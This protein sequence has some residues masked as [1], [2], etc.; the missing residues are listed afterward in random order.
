MVLKL[1]PDRS[2]GELCVLD[3][4]DKND[5]NAIDVWSGS[6]CQKTYDGKLRERGREL[7]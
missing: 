6:L 4:I 3:D 2:M 5:V 1:H 7:M